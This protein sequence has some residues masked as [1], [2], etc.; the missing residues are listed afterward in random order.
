[1]NFEVM[2]VFAKDLKPGQRFKFDR[3]K[4][5][6]S[7]SGFVDDDGRIVVVVKF[8]TCHGIELIDREAVVEL[9]DP[10][11]EPA[12]V[13]DLDTKSLSRQ[14]ALRL[15]TDTF[16][17][18]GKVA[19]RLILEIPNGFRDSWWTL[20]NACIAIEKELEREIPQSQ[21]DG[22]TQVASPYRKYTDEELLGLL[23]SK[24]R[25]K[26]RKL[27]GYVVTDVCDGMAVI[28]G[29]AVKSD[30]LLAEYEHLNGTPC[31]MNRNGD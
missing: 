28:E 31:G 12:K 3:S 6:A 18:N 27:T 5:E 16:V 30:E 10:P 24:V 20:P 25:P 23:L 8:A 17:N 14:I 4:R 13:K 19:K 29:R 7:A 21:P 26:G 15:F 22:A 9:I 11:D 2:T 1:M